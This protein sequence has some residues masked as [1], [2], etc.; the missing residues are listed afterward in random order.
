MVRVYNTPML[1]PHITRSQ[2]F[3]A[4]AAPSTS[5]RKAGEW[6]PTKRS[7]WRALGT[8]FGQLRGRYSVQPPTGPGNPCCS[9]RLS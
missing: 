4:P 6:H 1:F 2:L 7:A 3:Q 8:S 9:L 5:A